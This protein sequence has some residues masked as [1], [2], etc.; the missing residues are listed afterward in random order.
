MS[1][2]KKY[3]LPNIFVI[4]FALILLWLGH[5][6]RYGR[7]INELTV[8]VTMLFLVIEMWR[9]RSLFRKDPKIII[10][11]I[12]ALIFIPFVIVAVMAAFIGPKA[13]FFWVFV[14]ILPYVV[15]GYYISPKS[16]FF[17]YLFLGW[18]TFFAQIMILNDWI[19]AMT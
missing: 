16:P 10:S 13:F 6:G 9:K 18:Y 5:I 2:I 11:I 17:S 4:L 3:L 19:R 8:L 1:I 15:F 7:V 14:M 12:L